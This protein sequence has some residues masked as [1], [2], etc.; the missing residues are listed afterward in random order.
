M[1]SPLIACVPNVSEGRKL[2]VI[3]R[4]E[5]AIESVD[6]VRLL[7]TDRAEGPNRTVFAFAGP[8]AAV[9]E[10]AFRM[11]EVA[12]SHI[13][14]RSHTGTHP[15]QGAIDVCPFVPIHDIS[16]EDTAEYARQLGF[17]IAE[18]LD[19]VGWFYEASATSP[20]RKSLA[21]LRSGEYEAL[22][23][24]V[25]QPEWEPDFGSWSNESWH[26]MGA[27]VIGGRDPIVSYN[28]DLDTDDVDIAQRVAEAIREKGHTVFH[29]DGTTEKVP[30]LLKG[31]RAI[32]R[33][34]P[35][36]GNAQ[37]SCTICDVN[38]S[39]PGK[40]YRAV[41]REAADLGVHVIGSELIGLIPQDVLV[42]SARDL[43]VP[44]PGDLPSMLNAV[45]VLQLNH[46]RPFEIEDRVIERAM[47]R[48]K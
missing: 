6:E 35:E 10:A 29:S 5:D 28:I 8:P 37:V 34:I 48:R 4:L 41:Q 1:S 36:Y 30:G 33:Y 31:V 7:L 25:N 21:R 3:R 11:Y 2:D 22:E 13:D 20:D 47:K 24:K 27:T 18:E 45:H 42:Q 16:L 39:T 12:L 19:A 38:R 32:G 23:R 40:I 17:R 14:M 43:S 46:R 26:G 44:E 15:R 9:T